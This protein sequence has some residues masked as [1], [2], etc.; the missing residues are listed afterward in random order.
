[1]TSKYAKLLY[2]IKTQLFVSLYPGAYEKFFFQ[3]WGAYSRKYSNAPNK[4]PGGHYYI[5]ALNKPLPEA[6]FL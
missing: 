1:M 6:Y 2:K 3:E 5:S 4:P